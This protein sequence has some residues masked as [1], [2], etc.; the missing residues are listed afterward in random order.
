MGMMT[1]DFTLS[2]SLQTLAHKRPLAW[3]DSRIDH[4]V[5]FVRFWLHES[6]V[7]EEEKAIEIAGEQH[8]WHLS[9]LYVSKKL[10]LSA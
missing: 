5:D 2:F 6:A 10:N 7:V 1:G 4:T 8:L 3:V 9:E